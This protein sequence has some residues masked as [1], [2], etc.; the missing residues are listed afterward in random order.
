MRKPRYL[1]LFVFMLLTLLS[2][3]QLAAQ[4]N[5]AIWTTTGT[6]GD[7]TQDTNHFTAGDQVYI[8][9]NNFDPGTYAWSIEGKPGGASC[10][11]RIVIASG[12]VTVDASKAFCLYAYT[13]APDDCGEY[14]VNFGNKNDNY[15][16]EGTAALD[17]TAINLNADWQK[18]VTWAIQKQATPNTI[19]QLRGDVT[20]VRYTISLDQTVVE[21]PAVISGTVQLVNNGSEAPENFQLTITLKYLGATVDQALITTY[22]AGGSYPFSF[23]LAAPVAGTY[24]VEAVAQVSNGSG[25]T[26]TNSTALAQQIN[27]YPSIHVQDGTRAWG[28]AGDGQGGYTVDLACDA[29]AGVRNNTATIVETGQ[30]ASAAVTVTC[31]ALEVSKTAATTYD[32][33]YLWAIRKS[34]D[35]SDVTVPIQLP[36]DPVAPPLL[37]AVN[38]TVEVTNTGFTDSNW[39]AGGTITVHNPAPVPAVIKRVTDVMPATAVQADFGVTFPYLLPAGASLIGTWSADLADASS[40]TNTATA[41]I[42]TH[43]YPVGG[44][45][46][47]IGESAFS[48]TAAILFGPP[49]QLIDECVQVADNQAGSLGTVCVENA[50]Q[51]FTYTRTY[52]P[53]TPQQCG[54]NLDR[55][56]VA[57]LITNDTGTTLH[58]AWPLAI[59]VSCQAPQ[60]APLGAKACCIDPFVYKPTMRVHFEVTNPNAVAVEIPHGLANA[61]DPVVYQ[62]Q[63]PTLFAPGVTEWEVEIGRYE[64]LQ[65]LLDGSVA[66]ASLKLEV[67]TYAGQDDVY[68]AGVGVFYDTNH[69]GQYDAGE[70]LLAPDFAGKIG[71][72]YLVDAAGQM[73]DS[74]PLAGELFFRAGRQ[75]NFNMRQ[76]WGENYL[77]PQLSVPLPAGYRLYPNYRIVHTSEFPEPFYSLNNDFGL[78]PAGFVPDPLTSLD[79]PPVAALEW[80]LAHPVKPGVAVQASEAAQIAVLPAAFALEQNYPNPFNPQTTIRYDLPEAGHVTLS[81]FDVSG[82]LVARLADGE[83]AA[84]SYSRTWNAAGNPSGLY[85]CEL[86]TASFRQIRR[87]LLL[88]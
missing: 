32:R 85:F 71:E 34:G 1:S 48:G 47:E 39:R 19:D 56:N 44:Q 12:S 22:A 61:L 84:G 31:H 73:L 65:W 79:L 33:T 77:V 59:H 37:T 5:G 30:S 9:G 6:C 20:Q 11:P 81:V 8:N 75:V 58:S 17:I 57:S 26:S 50:P 38:Y 36:F 69:N 80:Y 82:H 25:D 68:I 64:V 54:E 18:T 70:S 4:G 78:V 76:V 16:V 45:P 87:M 52:G 28:F 10:D 27:G 63:Q 88:K 74:R 14:S 49:L 13:I 3:H 86:R 83:Q 21:S 23:A 66:T 51:T 7:D 40:R 24:V 29:D 43:Y 67:C 53:W 62:G 2:A 35:K 60:R 41:V 15:R 55:T 42:A 46:S 72:V